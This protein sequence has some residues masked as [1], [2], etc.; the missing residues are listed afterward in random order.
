MP[1]LQPN[2]S[3]S[4]ASDQIAEAIQ[5]LAI[6]VKYLGT[7]DA[8]TTMGAVEFLATKIDEAGACI[9][10]ALDRVAASNEEITAAIFE[11]AKAI[12][13][14]LASKRNDTD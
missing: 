7:G 3:P 12:A 6:H 9:A 13:D 2:A 8:A 5:A 11:G 14:S 10:D 4:S 1:Q